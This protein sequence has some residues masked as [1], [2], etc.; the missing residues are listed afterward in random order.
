MGV[1]FIKIQKKENDVSVE[2][3]NP[4]EMDT[5]TNNQLIKIYNL[6]L[7][8]CSAI[9]VDFIIYAYV[10]YNLK[11]LYI[12]KSNTIKLH[13]DISNRVDAKKVILYRITSLN[14][15]YINDNEQQANSLTF[16]YQQYFSEYDNIELAEFCPECG[17]CIDWCECNKLNV[18]TFDG[19]NDIECLRM[20][21]DEEKNILEEKLLIFCLKIFIKLKML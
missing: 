4:N 5:T 1:Q 10:T 3:C 2:N 9:D 11:P 16:F 20:I 19:Y 15:Q 7:D 6:A 8:M 14:G 13:N 17:C 18:E 12:P 21:S